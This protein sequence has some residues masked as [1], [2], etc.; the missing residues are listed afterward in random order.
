MLSTFTPIGIVVP[1]LGLFG[2]MTLAVEKR[3]KKIGIE[4]I[5]GTSAGGRA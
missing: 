5:L 1:C 4:K 3:V 2:L